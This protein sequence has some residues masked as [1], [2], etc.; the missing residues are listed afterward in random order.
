[1]TRSEIDKTLKSAA[2]ADLRGYTAARESSVFYPVPGLGVLRIKGPDRLD[3]LQRQT[4]NDLKLLSPGQMLTTILTSA[5]GRVL[6]VL[7][8][9]DFPPEEPRADAYLTITLPGKGSQTASFLQNKIFFMDKVTVEDVSTGYHVFTLEGPGM[10]RALKTANL[11]MVTE[12]EVA[13]AELNGSAVLL[14]ALP[15]QMGAGVRLVAPAASV[16][17][18]VA[19]LAQAPAEAIDPETANILRVERGLPGVPGELSGEYTPLE[20]NLDWAISNNKGCYTG[21]EVIARQI[22][23]D[24]VT[25]KLVGLKLQGEAEIGDNVWVEGKTVGAITSYAFSPRGGPLALAVLKRPH[26][27]TG[28]QVQV[29][30]RASGKAGE[31]HSLPFTLDLE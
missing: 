21:Q 29:G 17:E 31:V 19:R 20:T 23:Y 1:M 6:D 16:D 2:Q 27:Q 11:P 25:R 18:L 9:I 14:F 4:T 13:S 15:A 22:T 7:I 5:A 3:F 30:E 10:A 24:K 8:L 12:S 28:T 26:H